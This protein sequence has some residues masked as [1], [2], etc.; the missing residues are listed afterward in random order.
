MKL[1][2]QHLRF[3]QEQ[4]TPLPSWWRQIAQPPACKIVRT[5]DVNDL[6]NSQG[7]RTRYYEAANFCELLKLAVRRNGEDLMRYLWEIE[8][9]NHPTNS[10]RRRGFARK[11]RRKILERRTP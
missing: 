6:I 2:A 3:Y 11:W 9:M 4:K 10:D 1:T 5:I 8:R 7:E